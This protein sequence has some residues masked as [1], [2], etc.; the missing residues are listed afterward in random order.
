MKHS[1][2]HHRY[3]E[4]NLLLLHLHTPSQSIADHVFEM[5]ILTSAGKKNNNYTST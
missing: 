1:I 5:H 2:V 3:G 4:G